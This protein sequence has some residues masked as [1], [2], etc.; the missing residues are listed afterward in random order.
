MAA[1]S[2]FRA[3]A[4][5]LNDDLPGEVVGPGFIPAPDA[6]AV[7]C[8]IELFHAVPDLAVRGVG[9]SIPDIR[10]GVPL[11][12]FGHVAEEYVQVDHVIARAE[13]QEVELV[14]H[15]LADTVLSETVAETAGDCLRAVENGR[16]AGC[17]AF[18]ELGRPVRQVVGVSGN[19][20]TVVLNSGIGTSHVL[21][22][23]SQGSDQVDGFQGVDTANNISAP[24]KDTDRIVG[25][26][27]TVAVSGNMNAPV[28]PSRGIEVA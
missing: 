26:T 2:A 6:E 17:A 4:V 1:E 27:V 22:C 11:D 24:G 8:G 15:R 14:F 19:I 5:S 12:V 16:S 9:H 25:N 23:F 28:P 20:E 18:A 3:V 7:A 13:V 10:V 21:A